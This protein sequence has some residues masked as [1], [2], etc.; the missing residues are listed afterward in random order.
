MTKGADIP[1]KYGPC[2]SASAPPLHVLVEGLMLPEGGSEFKSFKLVIAV[3]PIKRMYL[4]RL[5]KTLTGH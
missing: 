5:R 3:I 4:E 1:S 2:W